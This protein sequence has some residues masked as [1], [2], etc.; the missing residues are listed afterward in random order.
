MGRKWIDLTGKKE[1]YMET[2]FRLAREQYLPRTGEVCKECRSSY[3]PGLKDKTG[4]RC[5]PCF[6]EI[7]KA[8][9]GTRG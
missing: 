1:T 3:S 8:Q 2:L 6:R 5:L 7:L 9:R 4:E